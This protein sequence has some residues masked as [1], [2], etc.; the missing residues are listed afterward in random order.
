[1]P[2]LIITRFLQKSRTKYLIL[3]ILL[4]CLSLLIIYHNMG[5]SKQVPTSSS[6][7]ELGL[8]PV[9]SIQ[10]I[11]Q[12]NT[13]AEI[14][15]EKSREELKCSTVRPLKNV[16]ISTPE[17]YPTLNFKPP[18]RSYWNYT[19]ERRYLKIKENWDKLPLE[20]I[21]IPHSHND[22]GWLK[23]FD[24]YFMAFTAH[25]L[26]NMA[27]KLAKYRDMTFV[28]SEISFFSRWWNSLKNRPQIREQV[29][30]FLRNGQ[31]EILTGGWVMTDEGPAH[32]YGMIDQMIEGH[33]WMKTNLG[34]VPRTAWSVDSFGHSATVPYIL[35][36]SGLHNMVIQRT[37][38]A[39]KAYLAE[40]QQLDFWWRQEFDNLSSNNHSADILCQMMPFDL[41]SIKHS[42]GPDPDVC[43]QFD[44]RRIPGEY[45]ESRA[46]P[47]TPEKVAEKA[48]LLLGQYGRI[49][50]LFPHNVA[51]VPLGDDFRYNHDEEWDQQYENYA[52]IIEYI[53]SR[54]DWNAHVR[55]GT[56]KDFFNAVHKRMHFIGYD[57]IPTL[58]GDFHV[59]GDI[60]GE[61]HPSYWSGYYTTRPYWKHMCRDLQHWLRSA[62]ILYSLSRAYVT[63]NKLL[64]LLKRLD[65][66]Y[67]YLTQARDSLGLFQHHDAITGTSKEAVMADYG[68]RLFRAIRESK[69]IIA[70]AALYV[71]SEEAVKRSVDL[72]PAH[73]LTSYLYPDLDQ[74]QFD[75]LPEKVP[76]SIPPQGRK[77]AI[78]NSKAQSVTEP[79][80]LRIRNPFVKVL[81]PDDEEVPIQINPAWNGSVSV[82]GD[83]YELLFLSELTPLSL[84]TFTILPT[85][86]SPRPRSQV[87]IN[88][89]DAF[90]KQ[91]HNSIFSFQS[92]TDVDIELTNPFI[93]ARFSKQSGLLQSI[94]LK[95]HNIINKVALNLMAY[96]SE[97]FRSGAYLFHPL[98]NEPVQNIS[99][100]FPIIR[101]VKGP[102]CSEISA[103]YSNVVTITQRVYHTSS[104]LNNG[105][106]LDVLSDIA[107]LFDV[108]LEL[109]FR[110]TSDIKSG[111]I[112]YT[113]VNGFQMLKRKTL[114]YLPL[115][116]NYY[117]ATSAM[118]IE[119]EQSRLTMLLSHAHGVA[120]VNP[121]LMEV[122]LDRRL[123]GDDNRGLGEGVM[124]N[125]PT[126]SQ[127]WLLLEGMK[128]ADEVPSLSLNSHLI[129]SYMAYPPVVIATHSFEQRI[130]KSKVEFLQSPF[131]CNVELFN[132][133]TLPAY[134]EFEIPSNNSLLIL[135][136]KGISCRIKTLINQSCSYTQESVLKIDLKN[137]QLSSVYKTTLTGS[138]PVESTRNST[139]VQVN[140]MELASYN[141]TFS[142]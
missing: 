51:L 71:L 101:I 55:F 28:W 42:C 81:G 73:P 135:H 116:A 96:K 20:V 47:I 75:K 86:K 72:R 141:V 137:V 64:H 16:D 31:L 104:L 29:R 39:W 112:F 98:T 130:L 22:P 24:G 87:S 139:Y 26:N 123:R 111:N 37:H 114:G 102:I 100:R 12:I 128:P 43:L 21:I 59:Y 45:S 70:H 36:A 125:K 122:M 1:M 27:D 79:I 67:A 5:N 136:N 33:Q 65:Q 4:T 80:R 3:V 121:G 54:S 133:R 53:N 61:G 23:T 62:E 109:V 106:E 58:T 82:L 8:N 2:K 9:D 85:E 66:D 108:N 30:E 68:V 56:L 38:Y 90:A 50:S 46:S 44:F 113:D 138:G 48:E 126:I 124:D 35:R 99:G 32:Y 120:S 89:N 103:I 94:E 18:Y 119:D 57:H 91:P 131:P 84:T 10:L 88:L 115:E 118:Y 134:D 19:F 40:K 60:Y 14:G 15:R 132:L 92:P 13:E 110:V 63:Q 97:E 127:F 140:A 78:F 93:I 69:G 105:V 83:V 6:R 52:K 7:V 25:I 17:V 11:E 107:Q 76:L 95:E 34:I 74:T 142:S 41:Y 129:F 117:P 77:V 49:G